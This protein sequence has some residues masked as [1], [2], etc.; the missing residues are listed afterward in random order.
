MQNNQLIH[1][2]ENYGWKKINFKNRRLWIKGLIYNYSDFEIIRK[3]SYIKLKDIKKFLN[4]IDG[5]YAI[6]FETKDFIISAVDKISSI[7]IFYFFD[8]Q[9]YFVSPF[10]SKVKN[11]FKKALNQEQLLSVSMASYTIGEETIYKN[12]FSMRAGSV[13]IFKKHHNSLKY[14][15]YYQFDC[16]KINKDFNFK[17][18]KEQLSKLNLKIIKKLYDYSM[19]E[20]KTIVIPLSGGLD[21]R[22]IA[23]TLKSLGAKNVFCFSYGYKNN[24]ESAA[25]KKIYEMFNSKSFKKFRTIFDTYNCVS[26]LTE[27]YAIK[28][29]HKNKKLKNCIIV[30]GNTGDFISGGHILKFKISKKPKKTLENLISVFINKHF[31]LW[32]SLA[33]NKN[34]QT[35]K[36]LLKKELGNIKNLKNINKNNF[37]SLIEYL[38]YYNRQAK[39][40]SSKQRTYEY[41]NCEWA[42]PLW[43]KDYIEFW[44]TVGKEFKLNQKLYIST[45]IEN[46]LG[47][48]WSEK[49]LK[50]RLI[51]KTTKPIFRFIIRPL[52]KA[53]F[54]FKG[55]KAWHS[56]ETKYLFFFNDIICA[57]GMKKYS[58]LI[59]D[60]R[61]FR[62]GL[63]LH[64]EDYLL[65]KNIKI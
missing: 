24:Y 60:K 61:G 46:N 48:V 37:H 13:S 53:L 31:R 43:D 7:P 17:K 30:N 39:H 14:F 4:S 16:W 21:S 49:W 25:N 42:L 15:N 2:D 65:K 57:M 20:E 1:I 22:L 19:R 10:P 51:T 26:D 58:H 64:T 59:S 11:F 9:N 54:F 62:N 45:L 29:L 18:K 5:H 23:S 56:F 3:L 27:F 50:Y 44:R 8:Q 33:T 6:I 38:E 32:Q 41:F 12:F 63:S 28:E 52:F 40:L 36:K 35:I 55:K 34:D 47:N